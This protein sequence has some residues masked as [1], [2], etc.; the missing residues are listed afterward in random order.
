[1][2]RGWLIILMMII[3]L[4]P[5]CAGV[6]LV[7]TLPDYVRSVYVPM[8][9]NNTYEPGLEEVLTN[10]TIDEFLA[11]GRLRVEEKA[12]ADVTVRIEIEGY[13]GIPI[14]FARDDFAA[15]SRVTA[16]AKIEV[17]DNLTGQTLAVFRDVKASYGYISDPRRV[18]E[19]TEPQVKEEVLR[20]LAAVIVRQVL[21]GAYEQTK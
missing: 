12:R 13:D 18:I 1:M 9:K 2:K 5:G 6:P 3:F 7:R 17:I 10:F 20:N 14:T 11:D 15:F 19:E 16:E 4:F 21:T 8:A